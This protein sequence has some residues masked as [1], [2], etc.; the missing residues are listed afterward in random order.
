M[1]FVTLHPLFSSLSGRMGNIVFFSRYGRQLARTY[2]VPTNRNSQKQREKRSLF[3]E[4]VKSWQGLSTEIKSKWKCKGARL[5]QT[6]YHC[7]L[8]FFMKNDLQNGGFC[9]GK[10][11]FAITE[12]ESTRFSF[13]TTPFQ[14][15]FSLTIQDGYSSTHYPVRKIQ[16][17][18][19]L[20]IKRFNRIIL[21]HRPGTDFDREFK[22]LASLNWSI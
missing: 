7:Y 21:L 17:G 19:S 10:G 16:S 14:I 15:R 9:D 22:K 12:W 13:A 11:S 5:G 6:G 4:A 1:A 2:V 18:S 3:A 20:F 8:S